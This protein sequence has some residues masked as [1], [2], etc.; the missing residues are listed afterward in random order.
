MTRSTFDADS[1]V[2]LPPHGRYSNERRAPCRVC[3]ES[4]LKSM[5]SQYGAQ[6]F[7]CFQTYCRAPQKPQKFP[8]LSP[9]RN[10]LFSHLGG[11]Q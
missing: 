8:I 6:C 2:P 10:S 4:T 11:D 7:E 9:R 1:E 3:D 5:L